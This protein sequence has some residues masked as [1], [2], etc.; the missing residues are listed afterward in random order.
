MFVELPVLRQRHK[1]ADD[2]LPQETTASVACRAVISVQYLQL[3]Q[4]LA[5]WT[6]ID[7]HLHN[8]ARQPFS[9]HF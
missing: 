3:F 2:R 6:G 8:A 5:Q 7:V 9:F 1:E 4:D